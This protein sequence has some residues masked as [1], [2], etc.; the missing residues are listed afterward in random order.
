M[1]EKLVIEYNKSENLS[2]TDGGGGAQ[3]ISP[4]GWVAVR[5]LVNTEGIFSQK[6]VHFISF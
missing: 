5:Y 6:H 4:F 1:S 2:L 3:N